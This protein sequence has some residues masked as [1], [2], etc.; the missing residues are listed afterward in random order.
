MMP[1]TRPL[2]LCCLVLAGCGASTPPYPA[3]VEQ[4]LAIHAA[5][6]PC[7]EDPERFDYRPLPAAGVMDWLI[8]PDSPTFDFQSGVSPFAAF[9]LPEAEGPFR[10]RVQ[11]LFDV[12]GEDTSVFYPILA[13]LDDAFVVTRVSYLDNLRLEQGLL[14]AEGEPGLAVVAPFDPRRTRERYMVIFTPGVL[15]NSPPP[16]DRPGDQVTLP[17]LDW[18]ERNSGAAVLASPYGRLRL[19][20]APIELPG[21]G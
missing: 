1:L 8:G 4:R 16:F 14:E 18:L 9:R 17:S 11:G 15:V 19:T 5:S 12:A 10:I 2:L 6:T 20:I 3:Q 21:A 13:M 7:C